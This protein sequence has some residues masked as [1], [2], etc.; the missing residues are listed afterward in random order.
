MNLALGDWHGA[1]RSVL[2][3]GSTGAGKSWLACALAQYACRCG[4]SSVYQRV[5]RL[6][7]EQRIRQGTTLRTVPQSA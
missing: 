2:L 6:Q 1:G 5:P 4:H 7:E 3:T